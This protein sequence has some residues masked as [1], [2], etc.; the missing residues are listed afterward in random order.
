[1]FDSIFATETTTSL[2]FLML[3]VSLAAGLISAFITSIK[4]RATKGF[5]VTTAL[6]PTIVSASFCFL[7]IMF[8]NTTASTVG[9]I[10]AIMVGLGL[11]RFRSAQGKAEE[12]FA[13]L[14]SVIVGAVAGLGFLTYAVIIAIVI[15]LIYTGL[16][17]ANIFKNKKLARE[18]TL[19]ITIPESLDYVDVFDKTFAHYLKEVEQVG[20]KTTGMGSMFRLSYRIVMKDPAEEKEFIDEL[21]T[22]NGNLEISVLPYSD[23]PRAL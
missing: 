23:D 6:M 14:T 9:R 4:L 20:V 15:P 3:G 7:N 11:I 16:M 21:R 10:A 22:F 1:M 12:M 13:L 17:S 8:Q 18:K 5:F 19:N 2:I